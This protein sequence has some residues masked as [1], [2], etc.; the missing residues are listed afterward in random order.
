LDAEGVAGQIGELPDAEAKLEKLVSLVSDIQTRP[1]DLT[2]VLLHRR[3]DNDVQIAT[4]ASS[5]TP[6]VDPGGDA[7]RTQREPFYA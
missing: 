1:D 3:E 4:I 5:R 6:V 2:L 7:H